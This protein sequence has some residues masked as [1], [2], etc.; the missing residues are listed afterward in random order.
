ML[1][2][3]NAQLSILKQHE[4]VQCLT[5]LTA[6]LGA[7]LTGRSTTVTLEEEAPVRSPSVP[8][9]NLSQHNGF[10][11]FSET[12]VQTA[13]TPPFLPINRAVGSAATTSASISSPDE[14]TTEGRQ[15]YFDGTYSNIAGNG[16]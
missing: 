7:G 6:V 2:H 1:T 4:M 11:S 16:Q 15:V 3:E 14:G 8:A 12:G 13:G 9:V 10:P 5:Q